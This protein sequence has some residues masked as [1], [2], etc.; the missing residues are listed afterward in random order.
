[1]AKQ[2][3]KDILDKIDKQTKEINAEQLIIEYISIGHSLRTA[4]EMVKAEGK[5]YSSKTFFKQLRENEELGKQYARA[6]DER[7]HLIFE[8]IIDITDEK[9]IDQVEVQQARLKVDARKWMLSKMNPKK[10]GDKI[11]VDANVNAEVKQT[12]IDY[13]GLSTET[14]MDLLKNSQ[15]SE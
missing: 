2:K 1:M 4:I 10:Y 15:K 8:E 13:S 11:E 9:M 3:N 7:T 14:L 6:C 12:N 5:P